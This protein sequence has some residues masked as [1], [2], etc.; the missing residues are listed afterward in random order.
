MSYSR[1][2]GTVRTTLSLPAELLEANDQAVRSGKVRSR[3]EFVAMALRHELAAQKRAEID[4][5]FA[6]MT[7]DPGYLAESLMIADEFALAEWEAFQ[8]AES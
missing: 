8:V 5:A 2:P 6:A 1:Q 7:D 3:N 4:A